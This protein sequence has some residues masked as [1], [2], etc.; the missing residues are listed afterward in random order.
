M[1]DDVDAYPLQWPVG[2]PRTKPEG[3]TRAHFGTV[4]GPTE[5]RTW[6]TRRNLTLA[7]GRDRL[8]T[9]L[10]RL[11]AQNW[12]ISTNVRV[13]RDGLLY[14]DAANPADP[15]AA[16][17]FQLPDER[18]IMRPQVLACD[19]WDRLADNLASIAAHIDA[20][21]RIDRYRVGTLAQAFAGYKALSAVG[22]KKPWWQVLG[23]EKYPTNYEQ[24]AKRFVDLMAKHHPDRGGN[25]NQAAEISAAWTEGKQEMGIE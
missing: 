7:E 24:A 20:L 3:R 11:C 2:W 13:R 12:V 18:G 17:Y 9:E 25:P 14:G 19:A 8:V 15:G 4:E 5:R 10:D 23:F 1:T 16:V 22:E 6:K 21:R